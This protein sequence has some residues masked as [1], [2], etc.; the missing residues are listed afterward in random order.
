MSNEH[1]PDIQAWLAGLGEKQRDEAEAL[2]ALVNTADP[3]IQQAVKWGRITF[4]VENRWHDWLCG[5]SAAK[6]GVRLV[7]HKGVLLDDPD[8][9]L[10]GSARYVREIPAQRAIGHPDAIRALI[11]SALTHQTDMLDR[12]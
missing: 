8:G 3:R 11:H 4:T 5:I 10:T 2:V 6:T 12:P 9:L 7:F 1:E